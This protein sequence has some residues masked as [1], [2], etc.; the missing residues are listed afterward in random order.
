MRKGGKGVVQAGIKG[1]LGGERVG[2]GQEPK[3][4]MG[5]RKEENVKCLSVL[6]KI[7]ASSVDAV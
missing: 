6:R 4:R 5:V 2:S 7:T 3:R 1:G